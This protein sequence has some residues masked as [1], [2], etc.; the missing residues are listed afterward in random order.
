M[1]VFTVI[2]LLLCALACVCLYAASPNQKLWTDAWPLWPAGLTAAALL[3]A[4]WLA[5][6]QDMQ[7]LP[8]TFCL[9]AMLMLAFSLLP[10][11]GAL[12]HGR[13]AR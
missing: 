6:V 7:R 13:R 2:G 5:L 12:V 3:V 8:A 4:G 9:L 1:P 10:Y 11:I